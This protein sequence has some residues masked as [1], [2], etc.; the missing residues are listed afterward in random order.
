MGTDV[1]DVAL[2]ISVFDIMDDHTGRRWPDIH[3]GLRLKEFINK[4]SRAGV[5]VRLYL[6]EQQ[7]DVAA[8]VMEA[9]GSSLDLDP[10]FFQLSIR[11]S[12]HGL[13]T[14]ERHRAPFISFTFGIPIPSTPCRTDA[15]KFKV[16]IYILPDAVG[17]G[18]TG[19]SYLLPLVLS[20]VITKAV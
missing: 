13:S 10:R 16:S 17:D 6:A 12:G 19:Q 14:S 1:E 15:E 8:G 9:L 2:V 4:E 20:L 5:K 7:G 3:D 18:W 11:G